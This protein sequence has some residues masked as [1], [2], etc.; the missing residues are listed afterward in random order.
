MLGM[1][2]TRGIDDALVDRAD[3]RDVMEELATR[4]LVEHVA[5]RWWTTRRGWLLGNEV[6]GA[7]WQGRPS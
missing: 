6:F 1:R 2:M 3:V 7:I 4:G 5:D